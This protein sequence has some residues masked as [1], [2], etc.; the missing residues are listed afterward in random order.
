MVL[1]NSGNS[2]PTFLTTSGSNITLTGNLTG[3]GGLVAKGT[4]ILTLGG[5]DT[6]SGATTVTGTGGRLLV[7]GSLSGT[8]SVTVNSGANLEVDGLL[9]STSAAAISGRLSGTGFV[10]GAT[11]LSSGTLAAGFSTGSTIAGTLTSTGNVV[12]SSTTGTLSIRL[13]LSTGASGDNDQLAMNNGSTLTL[14][15]T[16]L[17]L[18]LGAAEAGASAGNIYDIVSGGFTGT[19]T[20][21]DVF[22][23]APASGD[24]ITV[25]SQVF[26]VFYGVSAGSTTASGNDIAVELVSVPEPGTWAEIIAGIGILCIWQ[27]SRRKVRRQMPD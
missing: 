25:G 17:R 20:G 23:N 10:N 19:G 1:A 4:G 11:V 26:D 3:G 14:D 12:F 8:V 5:V 27:R 24:S 18:S 7:S 15:D 6:Y 21:T 13:G 9:T 2:G 16:T 22:G